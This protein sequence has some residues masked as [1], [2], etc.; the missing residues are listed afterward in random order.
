MSRKMS[1]GLTG[2]DADCCVGAKERDVAESMED[3]CESWGVK[4]PAKKRTQQS[5]T[6]GACWS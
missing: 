6:K 1:T 2:A 3:I 5:E 4:A